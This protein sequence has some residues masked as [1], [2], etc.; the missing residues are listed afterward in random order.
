M[1][2][3]KRRMVSPAGLPADRI[4]LDTSREYG[5]VLEGGGARG[6]FQIGVWR[7]LKE[8]GIRIRGISGVS[9][10]AL[11]GA[12]IC[13]GDL[14]QAEELW[15]QLNPAAVMNV[16][17]EPE[18]FSEAVAE[19]GRVIREGGLDAAP[20]RGLIHDTIDEEKIRKSDC[21]LFATTIS[22]TDRELVKQDVKAM[23]EGKIEEILMASAFFPLFKNEAL[24]GKWYTDGGSLDNVPVGPLLERD[25]RDIIVIRIYG[26]GLDR[27]KWQ[28]IPEGTR[29]YHIAPREDLG[30]ILEFD[31]RRIRKNMALGYLEACRFLYGLEG[32]RYYI[33]A[34]GSEAYY[35]DRMMSELELLKLYLKSVLDEETLRC[36]EGYRFYTEQIFPELARK[37]RL[38]ESWDY[39]DLYLAI[40][41]E[42]AQTA[43]VSRY[44]VYRDGELMRAI[45]KALGRQRG[46]TFG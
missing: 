35:F 10:G 33:D 20:L 37:L 5:I 14:E 15:E 9:V 16:N 34:P 29:V 41:E 31:S 44:H 4:V 36:L 23:P 21:E 32:R 8:A 45:Q 46:R 2:G 22:L 25:Y 28:K 24:S 18:S 30:G 12:L 27:E 3:K 42:L 40:L 13:M 17:L 26:W 43:R 7:A 11:N 39:R 38:K 1:A 6:A 19:L